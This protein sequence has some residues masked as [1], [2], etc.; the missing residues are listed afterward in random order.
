MAPLF[1]IAIVS[2]FLFISF[3]FRLSETT[4]CGGN[5]IASTITVNQCGCEG[6]FKSIQQAIDSIKS[7]NDQWVKIHIDAGTYTEEIEIPS[8]KPCLILEGEGS[9]NTI[10]QYN[11]HQTEKKNW[12]PTFHSNPPNVIV[13]GIT[14]K[15]TFN[16]GVPSHNFTQALAAGIFGDKSV[17][18]KCSFVG[19]QDT[20]LDSNG[21]HYFK[22]CFIQG[23]VDFIFGSG[24]SYYEDCIINVTGRNNSSLKGYIT[25]QSRSSENDPSGF[26]FKGGSI[27][28]N[29]DAYLGRAYGPYSRVIFYGTYFSSLV[30]PE[31]WYPWDYKGHEYV[32]TS[33]NNLIIVIFM[34]LFIHIPVNK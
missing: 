32:F 26:I 22:D 15:N 2:L 17:F 19:F 23:E 14:F 27:I 13:L 4:D 5:S 34:I 10:I 8:E 3:S 24:Q 1:Q 7:N 29:G 18:Y 16:L 20:L 6:G 11:D 9:E 30:A 28:G 25:A 21:R 33:S 31:G 12:R